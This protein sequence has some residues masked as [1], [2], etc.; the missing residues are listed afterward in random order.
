MKKI[1]IH[2]YAGHPFQIDLSRQLSKKYDVLHCYNASNTTP[3][4]KTKKTKNDLKSFNI[5]PITLSSKIDKNSLFKRWYQEVRYGI[6]LIK[7]IKEYS[8]DI[9]ISTNTP[10]DAQ[11]IIFIY[12]KFK[13][14]KFIFWLQDMIAFTA[15]VILKKRIKFLGSLV[16]LYFLFL[17]KN[18]AKFS[19]ITIVTMDSH[20]SILEKWGVKKEK[21]SLIHNWACLEDYPIMKKNNEWSKKHNY[22]NKFIFM[23]TGTMGMK[24]SPDLFIDL[25]EKFKNN[26]DIQIV[27]VSESQGADWLKEQKE[28][29]NIKNMDI[30]PYQDFKDVPNMMA[31]SDCLICIVGN[32]VADAAIPSKFSK[33]RF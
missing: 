32:D 2:D 17:E 6:K 19:D 30:L 1:L 14:I 24:H 13:K 5:A 31:A 9:I 33:R 29:L 4:G 7:T 28:K 23:W 20:I 3:Q 21:I 27:V 22:S 15:S 25:S 11:F 10:L 8:P 16:G 12:S 18:I 26:L